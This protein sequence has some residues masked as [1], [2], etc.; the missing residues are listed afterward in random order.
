MKLLV[1]TTGSFQF[2]YA[3]ER[4]PHNRPAVV[5]P[6][7]FWDAEIV[8]KSLVALSPL[9][10]EATDA[11]FVSTLKECEG[12]IN[13]AVASM[14]DRF[15]PKPT[16]SHKGEGQGEGEGEGDDDV[17]QSQGEDQGKKG[18]EA[19]IEKPNQNGKSGKKGSKP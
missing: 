9:S 10:G 15:G 1:E 4:V 17:D 3:G 11:E 14:I 12:D 6:N 18:E 16:T 7:H 13:L 5:A 8:K 2:I 19:P